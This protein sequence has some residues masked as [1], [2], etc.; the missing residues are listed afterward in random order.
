MKLPRQDVVTAVPIGLPFHWEAGH[1][2]RRWIGAL[3]VMQLKAGC[4]V[5]E[6]IVADTIGQFGVSCARP[7]FRGSA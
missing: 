3:P 7:R 5:F 6:Q 4:I 2:R 1:R